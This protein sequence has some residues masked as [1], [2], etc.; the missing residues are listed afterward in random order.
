MN[1]LVLSKKDCVISPSAE[2]SVL[3]QKVK[4]NKF[5]I[6]VND[7]AYDYVDNI[8]KELDLITKL[9]EGHKK[10]VIIFGDISARHKNLIKNIYTEFE[11][12]FIQPV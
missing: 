3:K 4:E 8:C 2:R 11:I 6:L 7:E 5:I 1:A 10:F 12:S 9:A